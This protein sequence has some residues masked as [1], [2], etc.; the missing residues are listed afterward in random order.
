MAWEPE[1]G[2]LSVPGGT[3]PSTVGVWRTE[4][5][6]QPLVVKRLGRPTPHDPPELSEPGHIGYWRREADV[7]VTGLPTPPRDYGALRRR[8]RRTRTASRS[9]ATGSRTRL[10]RTVSRALHGPVRRRRVRDPASSPANLMR[11]RMERVD[12]NGGWPTLDRT[13]VADVADHLWRHRASMLDLLDGCPRCRSTATQQHEP[14]GT[15]DDDAIAIDWGRSVSDRSAAT[16]AC[17][18]SSREGSSR[19]STPTCS[20]STPTPRPPDQVVL[21]AQIVAVYTA[22]SR[23]EW[24]LARVA[25][26]GRARLEVPPPRGRP[27]PADPAAAVPAHGSALLAL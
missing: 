17:S 4:R 13:A 6:G 10:E 15:G 9:C 23:A 8:P 2:W 22:L 3:G 12:R 21:G 27:A 19:C 24:A 25:A 14:A 16:S 1:P 7:I 20:V 5:G 11:D 18:L 26:G